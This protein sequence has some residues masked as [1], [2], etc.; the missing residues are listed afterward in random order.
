MKEESSL[1]LFRAE[2]AIESADLLLEQGYLA[3]SISRAY[4]AM[5]Y[6][7]EALLNE[8]DLSFSK[9]GNVHGAFGEHFIKTGI[10]DKK[11]HKWL[12][13]AFSRRIASDYDA[14]AKFQSSSVKTMIDQAWEFLETARNFLAR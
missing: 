8:K 7:A 5:F 4:Y 11:Y 10:L 2:E 9:H 12:L 3:D 1:L 14:A 13:E 6:I